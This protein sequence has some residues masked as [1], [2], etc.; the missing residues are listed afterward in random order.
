MT[1]HSCAFFSKK[2]A[3]QEQSCFSILLLFYNVHVLRYSLHM[4]RDR[5]EHESTVDKFLKSHKVSSE[6]LD[7]YFD[8]FFET[9][10]PV[11]WGFCF[12]WDKGVA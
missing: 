10:L 3:K 8:M 7:F 11:F 9:T 5:K 12:Y 4:F 6:Q 2:K 1:L